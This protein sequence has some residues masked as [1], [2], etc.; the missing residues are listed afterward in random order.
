MYGQT[1][2]YEKEGWIN[3]NEAKPEPKKK[4]K[5]AKI[6]MLDWGLFRMEWQTQGHMLESGTFSVKACD[7]LTLKNSKPTHWQ[8]IE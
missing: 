8:E 4:I 3:L 7:G 2:H 5:V 6:R 1:S